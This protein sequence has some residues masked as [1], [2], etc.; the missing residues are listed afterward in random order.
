MLNLILS[1]SSRFQ[2]RKKNGSSILRLCLLAV[3]LCLGD[4]RRV[5]GVDFLYSACTQVL[6][7]QPIGWTVERWDVSSGNA[8]LIEAS[9]LII[10]SSL[11]G[12]YADGIT[13]DYQ[14][15]LYASISN[16]GLVKKITPDGT[17]SQYANG[18]NRP[19]GLAFDT[20]GNLYVSN[21]NGV[22][23]KVTPLGSSNLFTSGFDYPQGLAMDNSGI[24]SVGS[25]NAIS[26]V[27]SSGNITLFASGIG[28]G[29]RQIT[30]D[31][32]GN[33]FVASNGHTVKKITSNGTVTTINADFTKLV[34]PTGIVSDSTG[35]LYVSNSGNGTISRMDTNGNISLTFNTVNIPGYLAYGTAVVP[36]P[37]TI[38]S[39]TIALGITMIILIYRKNSS[40]HLGGKKAFIDL[41][42]KPS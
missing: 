15:N 38:L 13:F 40:K 1:T 29:T 12:D 34:Y 16:A 26:K 36:E 37:S 3:L 23:K 32:I 14:G 2:F 7:T 10:A 19:S 6:S 27:D 42:R 17:I 39:G 8:A 20:S 18:F 25:T 21:N 24:L 41:L 31:T 11:D 35:Y 4:T 5:N 33:L 30:Y 22:I 28:T 9:R